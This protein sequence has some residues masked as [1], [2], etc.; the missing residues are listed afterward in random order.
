VEPLQAQFE[1]EMLDGGGDAA[2]F[3]R[4]QGITTE[5]I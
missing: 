3:V 1:V 4:G 5:S 2:L